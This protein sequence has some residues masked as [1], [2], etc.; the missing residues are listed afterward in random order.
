MYLCHRF[1]EYH[2]LPYLIELELE[3]IF[4]R[5][6]KL[7]TNLLSIQDSDLHN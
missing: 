5:L 3:V 7:F 4:I 6:S 1:N 2:P